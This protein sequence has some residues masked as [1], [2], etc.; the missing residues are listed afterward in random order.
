MREILFLK[1]AV[2]GLRF[3]QNRKDNLNPKL[4]AILFDEFKVKLCKKQEVIYHYGKLDI[5]ILNSL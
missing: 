3:F 2:E 1:R 5:L 4:Y